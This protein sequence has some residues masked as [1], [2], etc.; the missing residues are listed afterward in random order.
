MN[1]HLVAFQILK[2]AQILLKIT[3]TQCRSLTWVVENTLRPANIPLHIIAVGSETI[4]QH[5]VAFRDAQGHCLTDHDFRTSLP[6]NPG[7]PFDSFVKGISGGEEA[8]RDAFYG[9]EPYYQVN[10]DLYRLAAMTQGIWSPIR[11]PATNCYANQFHFDSEG[12]R[13]SACPANGT[14]ELNDPYCRPAGQQIV[15]AMAKILSDSPFRIVR[16]SG[17]E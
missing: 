1:F 7:R 12:R 13:R 3:E 15:E 16:E 9:F 2:I 17:P 8:L 10:V 6:D 11:P 14:R 4:G 5:T